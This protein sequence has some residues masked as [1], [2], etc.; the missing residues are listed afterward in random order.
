MPIRNMGTLLENIVLVEAFRILTAE[1]PTEVIE[2][3]NSFAM[4]PLAALREHPR[5]A[6]FSADQMN[7]LRAGDQPESDTYAG[8]LWAC[9]QQ[10]PEQP[11]TLGPSGMLLCAMLASGQG[12]P[13]RMW[14][15]D[16][17]EGHYG[18]ALPALAAINDSVQK[19][20]GLAHPP[21]NDVVACSVAYPSALKPPA[22]DNL[23]A[24]LAAWP[25]DPQARL[26]F[27]DPMRY[28]LA[29]PKAGET[30]SAD[31]RQW[32]SVL[33]GGFGRQVVAVHFTGHQN[34]LQLRSEVAQIRADGVAQGYTHAVTASHAH[35]HVVALL[36]DP[37]GEDATRA[38]ADALKTVIE[39]QWQ[40]WC[41]AIGRK[42]ACVLHVVVE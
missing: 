13:L 4:P 25:K 1:A 26:G 12:T 18:D 29:G 23:E 31:H 8:L 36:R 9:L 15:N 17:P 41:R 34:F 42:R 2:I 28:R 38:T 7:A 40:A 19:V 20:L 32:L 37:S 6:C 3:A 39:E 30:S 33:A 10:P 27:L 35:Y 24:T 5:D 22:P 11:G 16:I 21:S 14:L